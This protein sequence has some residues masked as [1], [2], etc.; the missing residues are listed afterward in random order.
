MTSPTPGSEPAAEGIRRERLPRVRQ[1]IAQRMRHSLQSTAQLTTVVEADVTDVLLLRDRIRPAVA[2][3]HGIKLSILP[4]VLLAVAEALK[5]YPIVNAFVD[6]EAKQIEFHDAQHLAVA[7]D[8]DRGLMA[9]VI[10]DAG[11]LGLTDLAVRVDEMARRARAGQLGGD[12]LNGGTFTVSNTGS[13]GALFDTP[14]VNPPQSAILGTGAVVR[15]VRP[16]PDPSGAEQFEVRS[17]MYLALSYDHQIIDGAD[18]ARF[19]AHVRGR[20]EQADFAVD[21]SSTPEFP[22]RQI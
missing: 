12:E 4:F 1:V 7:V 18:A 21:L 9:P 3:R 19:L 22:S 17:I 2:D 16:R 6:T 5:K 11:Q 10:F 14:I 20:L 15:Q 13:R 8:T